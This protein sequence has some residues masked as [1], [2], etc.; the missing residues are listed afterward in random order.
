MSLLSSHSNKIPIKML[1]LTSA[2]SGHVGPM[3]RSSLSFHGAISLDENRILVPS[4]SDIG[5]ASSFHYIMSAESNA[6]S[7]GWPGKRSNSNTRHVAKGLGD[8]VTDLCVRLPGLSLAFLWRVALAFAS[9]TY[10][11]CRFTKLGNNVTTS[12]A[13]V[14]VRH[15]MYRLTG[16][17]RK[18]THYETKSLGRFASDLVLN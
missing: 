8:R 12:A 16:W 10:R 15:A 13:S 7:N 4:D 6:V 14:K 5:S 9:C 3:S 2:S 11:T 18:R 17:Q 1:S